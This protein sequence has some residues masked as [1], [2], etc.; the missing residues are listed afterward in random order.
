MG[1]AVTTGLAL[2][3]LHFTIGTK[4]YVFLCHVF[5]VLILSFG[6]LLYKICVVE[7]LQRFRSTEVVL[8]SDSP[9]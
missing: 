3:C 7:Y 4:L 6:L 2:Q 1:T 5:T 8:V 9:L